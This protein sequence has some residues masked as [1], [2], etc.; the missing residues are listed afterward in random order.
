M[1]TRKTRKIVHT[2]QSNSAESTYDT[3]ILTLQKLLTVWEL[4]NLND[5]PYPLKSNFNEDQEN[6]VASILTDAQR[7]KATAIKDQSVES[8]S[9]H[10]FIASNC[11]ILG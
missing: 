11:R 2:S 4:A 8:D 6:K 7:R 3:T 5:Y 1:E 10:T 9:F